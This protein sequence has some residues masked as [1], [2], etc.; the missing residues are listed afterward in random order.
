MTT[1]AYPDA[2]DPLVSMPD[3]S[4][5]TPTPINTR[6]LANASHSARM[7]T[8]CGPPRLATTRPKSGISA[9]SAGVQPG[10]TRSVTA[11]S[12]PTGDTGGVTTETAPPETF[13]TARLEF[14]S[15]G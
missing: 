14:F 3:I 2:A 10:S 7:T 8:I 5:A 9:G 1:I 13:D 11:A 6:E 4:R 15:D 12:W